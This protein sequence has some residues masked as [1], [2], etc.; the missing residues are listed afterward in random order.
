VKVLFSEVFACPSGNAARTANLPQLG[1]TVKAGVADRLEAGDSIERPHWG[2]VTGMVQ[3]RTG[4][5]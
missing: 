4:V 1:Q 3:L 5:C 2:Q